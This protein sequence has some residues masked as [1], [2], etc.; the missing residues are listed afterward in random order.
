MGNIVRPITQELDKDARSCVEHRNQGE[1]GW[2]VCRDAAE[3]DWGKS[4]PRQGSRF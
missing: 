4:P 3:V 1:P 2:S